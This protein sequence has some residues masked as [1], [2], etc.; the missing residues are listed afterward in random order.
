MLNFTGLFR[1]RFSA[2]SRRPPPSR[3]SEMPSFPLFIMS[4]ATLRFSLDYRVK[5]DNDGGAE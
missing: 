1:W 5:P 2:L 4:A 3:E